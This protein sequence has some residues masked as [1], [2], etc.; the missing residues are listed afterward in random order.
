MSRKHKARL[1]LSISIHTQT[2]T[3]TIASSH[4]KPA[5]HHLLLALAPT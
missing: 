1:N 3:H 5:L 2:H 4:C